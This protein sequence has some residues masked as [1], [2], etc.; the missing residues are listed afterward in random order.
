MSRVKNDFVSKSIKKSLSEKPRRLRKN[1][2]S[3]DDYETDDDDIFTDDDDEDYETIDEDEDE[4]DDEDEEEEEEAVVKK[5]RSRRI[6][7]CEDEDSE[8]ITQYISRYFPHSK[9]S[10]KKYRKYEDEDD[11]DEDTSVD[12][13][14]NHKGKKYVTR[15]QSKK[16]DKVAKKDKLAKKEKKDKRHK[17]G[18]R[19]DK[20]KSSKNKRKYASESET[21]TDETYEDD[22]E[23][24]DDE[25][26]EDVEDEDED[27]NKVNI[28]FSL[29]K[30]DAEDYEAFFGD[31]DDSEELIENDDDD[32]GSDDEKTYMKEKYQEVIVP[33]SEEDDDKE[34]M[35][36]AKKDK[37]A[38]EEAESEVMDIEEEY[39]ELLD[40]KKHL[41]AKLLNKPKSRILRKSLDECKESINKLIKT[42]RMKNTKHYHKLI[43]GEK[44][45]TNEMD[46]FKKKLSN[47][48][49]LKI[50]KDLKEIN[51]H[52]H[53]EK[54]YRLSILQSKM[55]PKFK[56]IAMQKLNALKTMDPSDAEYHKIKNWVDNFMKIPFG[57]YK[58]LSVSMED[59]PE[60]CNEFLENAQ[61]TLDDCAYGLDDAKIQVMQMLGQWMS[62]P[63]AMGTSIA[64]K[65][66]PGT[67][68]CL[69]L[70][71][72][73]LMYD[74]SIKMVQDICV[75]DVI[76]GDDSMPRNIL[77]L[78][79]GKDEMYDI[80]SKK[81]DKYTVNSEHI[82]SLK[83]S[84]LN[85]IK[86]RR[87]KSG[88]ITYKV[89][90][91]HKTTCSLSYKNFK[92][93]EEA[94]EF[95]A[96]NAEKDYTVDI[97]VKNYLALP[98]YIRENLKGYKTG[99][100]FP[101]KPV[102]FN[103]YIMG[104]WLGDGTSA[105]TS[106]TN[107]D[108]KILYHVRNELHKV[109][110]SLIYHR[111]NSEDYRYNIAA[112]SENHIGGGSKK[113]SKNTFALAL[114]K[115]NLINNKHIPDDYKINCRDVQLQILAGLLD[116][117]GHYDKISNMFTII[118]KNKTLS[119]DILFIAR[120][121]GF[122]ATQ[123]KITSSCM[124]KE[125]KR[126]GTYY[127]IH[128]YG[129][130]LDDIPTQ[131]DRKRACSRIR[132][133][134]PLVN[135]IKVVP[136]GVDDYYGFEI[137]GNRRFVL[138]DFT[139]THNTTLIKEGIS[140][141]LGRE[142]VF[143]ALGGAGDGSFL[144]GHSY[145]YEGSTWGRIVQILID[146]KCMNPVIYFDE[147]DKISDTPRGQEIVGILTHLTDTTQNSQFHDKYFSEIDF[148]LSK[149]LFIFS[150]NDENLVNPILK[151]RMYRIQTKGYDAKEKTVIA[152]NYLLPKIR[153]Q[154]N[155]KEG[156]IIVPDDTVQYIISTQGFTKNEDGVRNL[157][158]CLE[159]IYTKLN[160]FRLV[161]PDNHIFSKKIDIKVEF[162]FTVT[163]K[164]ADVLLKND[165]NQNQSLLAMYV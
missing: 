91:F 98:S 94:T 30:G 154:V 28:I 127:R 84:G 3:D 149:C 138:A 5:K 31:E 55:P 57:I 153:E 102:E 124:Y 34:K 118:Q 160:L 15:S 70:N 49:Q 143:I 73:V 116:T 79:R 133:K 137:D 66:P 39:V 126:E 7:T 158:R 45:R 139:V 12:V 50:M 16:K 156:D 36:K 132:N 43:Q 27:N 18:K 26:E 87:Y 103:P 107:K 125:E 152:R 129:A 62:N 63:S 71:T 58:N 32:C 157:K 104:V 54:P 67:A 20:K 61:K 69:G 59:G 92:T 42:T 40:L 141:I 17:K 77:G 48:E 4:D 93:K 140:K 123:K 80:I 106:F 10:S 75:G 120:S 89:Q 108:T 112:D 8:S 81:G 155:F 110:L 111:C 24:E 136:V 23:D 131:C 86:Q 88:V 82:L 65:G 148:D 46:Y 147:L 145:T 33:K 161:K 64:I 109:N 97:T 144:E 163:R 78:G 134:N 1:R 135:E 14:S 60:A 35:K 76:M 151:D 22:E 53:I 146:S 128:I 113:I 11:D 99:I 90:L 122:G 130:R 100:E 13:R 19:D 119:D 164:H 101:E 121:L 72:P 47:K 162:P 105:T 115:Y 44:K 165:E 117:D 51:E 68:K 56:A 83:P 21:E 9:S 41:T 150:Y 38:K 159:I 95:L 29:G 37:K 6:V 2:P 74:G 52:I 85:L 114:R 25:D 96:E 142:F